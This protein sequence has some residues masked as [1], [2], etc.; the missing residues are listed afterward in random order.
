[1]RLKTIVP[2]R[3]FGKTIEVLSGITADDN[4]VLNPSDSLVDGAPVR[5]AAP[6]QKQATAPAGNAGKTS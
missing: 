3:D 6:P 1:M 5:I 4:I 2:G